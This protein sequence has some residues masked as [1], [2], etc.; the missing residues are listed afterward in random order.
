MALA[1]SLVTGT[2]VKAEPSSAAEGM[3]VG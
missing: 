2:F 1:H 3:L